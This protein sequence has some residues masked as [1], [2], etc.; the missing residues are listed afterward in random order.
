MQQSAF[1]LASADGDIHVVQQE[2]PNT[3]D[4]TDFSTHF[5]H[6]RSKLMQLSIAKGF[7]KPW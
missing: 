7:V 4:N 1:S 2:P 6:Q 5:I 3:Q